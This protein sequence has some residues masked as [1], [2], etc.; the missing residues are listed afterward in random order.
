MKIIRL[1][2]KRLLILLLAAVFAC[3]PGVFAQEAVLKDIIITNTRDDLLVYFKVQGAF[4]EKI[5]KAI[6]SGVPTS[7][8][9]LI[10]LYRVRDLWPD[11]EIADMRL[12]D[13]IKYDNLKKEFRVSRSWQTDNPRI[14]KSFDE[15]KKLM[16]DVDS[17]RVVPLNRLKKGLRYQLRA[18]AELSKHTLPFYLHYVLFFLSLWDFETDWYTIDFIY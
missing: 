5:E 15:A 10:A 7:F 17:L 16:T 14:V 6:L 4:T 1:S 8:S 12:T 3:P 13:T 11:E 2:G 9:F 18:K